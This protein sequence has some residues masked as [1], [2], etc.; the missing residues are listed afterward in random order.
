MRD[1]SI[2]LGH[3]RTLAAHHPTKRF[4][5]LY[6]LLQHVGLLSLAQARISTNRGAHTPGVDG[7]TMADITAPALVD[8]SDEL[9]AGTY[10]SK[11]VRRVYV[12][13]KNGTLRPLGIPTSRDKIVQAGVALILEALY[14]PLF[15]PC[16]HGFRP[17]HSPITALRHVSTAYRAGA[18]WIIEGDITNCFGNLP[19][20]VILNC[21]R[22]RIRDER[23]ID[24]IRKLLQAGVMEAGTL[25][26]TY[27]GTPQGGVASPILANIALHELDVW[28]EHHLGVNPPPL[29]P[30]DQHARSNPDYMRLHS[31]IVSLRRCLDGKRRMPPDTTPEQLRQELR[32]TLQLRC[33]QPRLLPRRAIYYT[34]Y[35]DDFLIVL[36]HTSKAEAETVKQTVADWM[37]DNLGLTLHEEKTHITHWRDTVPFLGYTLEGR[38][39]RNGTGWLYLGVARDAIRRVTAKVQQATRYPQAP[40]YDVF[41]NINAIARGWSNYYRYA[42][43]A[44]NVGGKL[45]TIVYWRTVHYLAMRRRRSIAAVM[46]DSYARDPRTGCLALFVATPGKSQTPEHRYFLWHKL[47]PRLPLNAVPTYQVQDREAYLNLGWARGR[48]THKKLATRAEAG[49]QCARCGADASTHEV[50][51]PHRL[52]KVK[53]VKKGWGHVAQSGMDQQT[54]LLCRRCHM[55]HHTAAGL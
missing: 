12:P 38:S 22:K 48:S 36:C 23:F 44:T 32:A 30:K 52:S 27:S 15:R 26:P 20:G 33:R 42:H 45:S 9:T 49:N 1:V 24:L 53:R 40:E 21:L 25:T 19:H 10:R 41:Q 35:A 18:T 34:R 16:S 28:L 2:E 47:L 13:K 5:R 7:Q 3:L 54:T 51:H 6:R 17:G 11:P 37:R 31:R 39:N 8:L 29:T 4:N 46:R 55:A 50:H 14:E 43:N